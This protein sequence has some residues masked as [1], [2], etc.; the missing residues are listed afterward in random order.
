MKT[1]P[2]RDHEYGSTRSCSCDTVQKQG[3]QVPENLKGQ[4]WQ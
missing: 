3:C 4:I 2:G 1:I